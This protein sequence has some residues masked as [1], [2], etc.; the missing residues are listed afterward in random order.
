[1][2]FFLPPHLRYLLATLVASMVICLNSPDKTRNVEVRILL[3][4]LRR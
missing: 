1:M 3:A 4:Q 2:I